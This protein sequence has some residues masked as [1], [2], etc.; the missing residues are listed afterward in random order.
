MHSI[1]IKYIYVS[2]KIATFWT[3]NT[4]TNNLFINKVF[5]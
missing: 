1:I 3:L 2:H 4:A 5:Y